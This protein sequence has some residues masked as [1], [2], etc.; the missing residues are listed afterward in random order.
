MYKYN[1]RDW[2]LLYSLAGGSQFDWICQS[3]SQSQRCYDRRSFGESVLVSSFILDRRPDFLYCQTV[4][5]LLMWGALSDERT[6]CHLQ[7]LLALASAVILG[8]ESHGT[9]DHIL[10]PQILDSSNLEGQ[11]LVFT[12]RRNTDASLNPMHWFPFSSSHTTRR[13]TMEVFV[14]GSTRHSRLTMSKSKSRYDWQA[15]GQ[16]VLLWSPIWGRWQNFSYCQTVAVLS[17]WGALSDPRTALSCTA[18]K[19]SSTCLLHSQ[20]NMSAF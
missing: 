18:V 1:F 14:T 4:A 6:A 13:V 20:L 8:S 2:R 5:G 15:V 16:L 17:I 7:L 10:L 9:N 11:V 19:I 12:S 3:Q